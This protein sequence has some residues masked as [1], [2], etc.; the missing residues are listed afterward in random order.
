MMLERR[1]IMKLIYLIFEEQSVESFT[2][3]RFQIVKYV[4]FLLG[5]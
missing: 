5:P 3:R 2:V 4:V 1:N